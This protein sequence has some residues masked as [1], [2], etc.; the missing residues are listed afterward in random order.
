MLQRG[1]VFL[2]RWQR[3][4]FCTYYAN[5]LSL[6]CT[7]ALKNGATF[8]L[9]RAWLRSVRWVPRGWL[10][11]RARSDEGATRERQA[12]QH[13]ICAVVVSRWAL[14]RSARVCQPWGGQ[15][16]AV[17]V[18]SVSRGEVSRQPWRSA[19]VCWLCSARG[20]RLAPLA[21]PSLRRSAFF[22]ACLR[23]VCR[24]RWRRCRCRFASPSGRFALPPAVPPPAAK[25]GFGHSREKKPP[26]F[27]FGHLPATASQPPRAEQSQQTRADRHGCRRTSPRLTDATATADG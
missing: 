11:E 10:A 20:G 16:S 13:G 12:S 27:R 18:A 19:R 2:F 4:I 22:S 26:A 8:Y 5:V 1:D 25:R 3:Y 9:V 23:P 17:A 14:W 15:P 7:I 24:C 6:F 21:V